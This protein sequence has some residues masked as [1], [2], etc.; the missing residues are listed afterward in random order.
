[1]GTDLGSSEG[2]LQRERETCKQA[3]LRNE[4]KIY[5]LVDCEIHYVCNT[6]RKIK[7]VYNSHCI[8]DAIKLCNFKREKLLN[9]L[10]VFMGKLEKKK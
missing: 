6:T 5:N 9:A 2:G 4:H 8:H 1:M 7:R 10:R 3:V